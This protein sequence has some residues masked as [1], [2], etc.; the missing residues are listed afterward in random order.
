[1]RKTKIDIIVCEDNTLIQVE[2][3]SNLQAY[4]RYLFVQKD[5][6]IWHLAK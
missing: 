5:K 2:C 1:M 4:I 3:N 6:N